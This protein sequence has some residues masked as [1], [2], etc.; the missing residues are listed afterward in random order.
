MDPYLEDPAVW[1]DFHSTF[2]NAWRE[3]IAK[4]L[5]EGYIAWIDERVSLVRL[6]EEQSLAV[7]PDIAVTQ[8][9]P[10]AGGATAMLE[11][12]TPP[13]AY[14]AFITR[15]TR[16]TWCDVY[17]WPMG[18]ALPTLPVPLLPPDADISVD[19]SA[20]FALTYERGRYR[21]SLRYGQPPSAP[22]DVDQQRWVIDV[23]KTAR[24]TGT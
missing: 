2:I 19:L 22:L 6:T 9:Q 13:G 3:A 11:D 18:R 14:Y 1:R 10:R 8:R 21:P 12:L 23:A 5:P 7:Y 20:V 15:G 17:A 16:W 24:H 4:Q